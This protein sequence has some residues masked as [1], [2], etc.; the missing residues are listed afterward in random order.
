MTQQNPIASSSRL[1]FPPRLIVALVLTALALVFLMQNNQMITIR[2]LIPVVTM[3]LWVALGSMLIVG[4]GIGYALHW[5][6]R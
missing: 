2:L 6:R 3:P 4:V 1:R 5:R